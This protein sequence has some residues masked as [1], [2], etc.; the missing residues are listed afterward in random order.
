MSQ[1]VS[2][3]W[4]RLRLHH[5]TLNTGHVLENRLA[6]MTQPRL[7]TKV[8]IDAVRPLA[9]HMARLLSNELVPVRELLPAH[10]PEFQPYAIRGFPD[11]GVAGPVFGSVTAEC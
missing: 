7:G 6:E 1:Q 10:A 11:L 8:S 2:R 3:R 4:K 9:T 5:A